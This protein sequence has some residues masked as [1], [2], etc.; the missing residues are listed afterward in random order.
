MSLFE[1]I[2]PVMRYRGPSELAG[3]TCTA[4]SNTQEFVL[5][6]KCIYMFLACA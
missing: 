5:P 3:T 2:G 4:R 6:T 1:I